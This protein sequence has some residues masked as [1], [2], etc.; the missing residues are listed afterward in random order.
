MLPL[1]PAYSPLPLPLCVL[2]NT[3]ALCSITAFGAPYAYCKEV[4]VSSNVLL[5]RVY[6]QDRKY[7]DVE[8]PPFLRVVQ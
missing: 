2:L 7:E 4:S 5:G 3:R 6:F 1:P 8:L